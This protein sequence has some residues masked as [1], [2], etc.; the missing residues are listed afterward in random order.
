MLLI[1]VMLGSIVEPP[2]QA[3]AMTIGAG[4]LAGAGVITGGAVLA[5]AAAVVAVG[6]GVVYTVDNWD[7]WTM[8]LANALDG[9][10]WWESA[11]EELV[12]PDTGTTLKEDRQ[13]NIIKFPGKYNYDPKNGMP[14][15]FD[16]N[17][18]IK[19]TQEMKRQ[20]KWVVMEPTNAVDLWELMM[21]KTNIDI[22]GKNTMYDN[23]SNL[24]ALTIPTT[25]P[26]FV[27]SNTDLKVVLRFNHSAANKKIEWTVR[28]MTHDGKAANVITQKLV[29]D[30]IVTSNWYEDLGTVYNFSYPAADGNTVNT[31]MR[32][33]SKE[34][35][36][37]INESINTI[38]YTRKNLIIEPTVNTNTIL[39][40]DASKFTGTIQ[41]SDVIIDT[42]L[43]EPYEP[44]NNEDLKIIVNDFIY[45]EL[46][47]KTVQNMSDTDKII[48]AIND[49]AVSAQNAKTPIVNVEVKPQVDPVEK[50]YQSGVLGWLE[51]IWDS[52]TDFFKNGWQWL[53][54]GISDI[55]Q[56]L[57]D[58]L[59]AILG[60]PEMLF[61]WLFIPDAVYLNQKLTKW[62]NNFKNRYGILDYP[63]NLLIKFL[64]GLIVAEIHDAVLT[65]PR[66]EYKGFLLF[67]GT[68]FNFTEFVN[69]KE[70]APIYQSYRTV[71]SYILI[72]GLVALTAKK[73]DKMLRG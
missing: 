65:I 39:W 21:E 22:N 4:A 72:I 47:G 17:T 53:K 10:G 46:D 27:M 73:G 64:N 34:F 41:A 26:S 32:Y 44:T 56:Y 63:I 58:L 29:T 3:Q 11:A 49:A 57:E 60:L 54:D 68:S 7:D 59:N 14:M 51:K 33:P 16:H 61:D 35:L 50:E 18:I 19:I 6:A 1:V 2:K 69:R 45:K 24:V 66:I 71:V 70:F 30:S 25:E 55:I 52:I 31:L 8:G 36:D 20:K 48:K 12:D 40:Y 28:I 38:I 62:D 42:S 67:E 43:Y 23:F 13:N 9:V 15:V 37:A 5:I